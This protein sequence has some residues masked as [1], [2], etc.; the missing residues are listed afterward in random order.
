[1]LT[2][3]YRMIV[4]YLGSKQVY[5]AQA[6]ELPS[7][8]A[9]GT[10][11]SEAMAKLE[12]EMAAQVENM[13]T[14]GVEIPSPVEDLEFDG[15]LTLKVSPA[16]HRDLAFMAKADAVEMDVL[17]T[18]M[19]AR[20]VSQH[21]GGAG[22]GRPRDG[23]SR[24]QEGQGSRYHNIMENRADF[25]EYVRSLDTG[26]GHGRGGGRRGGGGGGGGGRR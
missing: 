16:L 13:Q 21:W 10:T 20:E 14:K 15:N 1:M 7:C 8:Q 5:V 3:H 4:S 24:P 26:G 19:L 22:R 11:R 18:E 9:E 17:L 25:I 12:V 2:M 6:P 23:R